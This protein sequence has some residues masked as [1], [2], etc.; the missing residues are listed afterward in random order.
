MKLKDLLDGI[1]ILDQ[2]CDLSVDIDAIA[3]DSRKVRQGSLF[4]CIE[5]Y[6]TDGHRYALQAQNQSV[7]AILLQKPVDGLTVPWVRVADT[8][9]ALAYVSDRFFNHPSGR[10]ELIGL[11][12]TK[13]KTTATYMTR[14]ILA[15][16]GR[17]VGLIGTNQNMIGERV[18]PT[19][20]TTPESYELQKLFRRMA[21]KGDIYL[22][23]YEGWYSVRDEAYYDE[24]ELVAGP[25]GCKLSPQGT[26]V[27]W[28]V[29]ES[30]FFRLSAY[31]DRLLAFYDANPDFIQPASRRNE[32]INF[33][34][35]G[36]SDLSISRTSFDWGVPVP[37]APGHVMY[38]WVDALTN[39]LTG[40]GFPGA[41][42]TARW[43]ADVHVIGKDVVRFHAIYWPAFLM[44]ADV[45]LPGCVFGH[46]FVLN[47]GEKM[48]K[49]LGNVVEPLALAELYGVD[50]LRYFLLR[51]VPFGQDGSYSHD[52]IVARINGDLAN[53]LGNLAQR[54][55]SMIAKN[56]D[57]ILPA[58]GPRT[59]EDEA[60]YARLDALPGEVDAAMQHF[61]LHQ[62]LEQV[63][64]VVSEA[65]GYIAAQAPWTVRKT[66]PER[67]ATILYNVA[68]AVRRFA[69]LIQPAMPVSGGKLLD[70]LAVPADC[71]DFAALSHPLKPGLQLPAPEGVFPRWVEADA[72]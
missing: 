57:G 58:P 62:A 70:L 60:F 42:Y 69:I 51:E 17:K 29:E 67:A 37:D 16:D 65:N 22:D 19:E 43:P 12:G 11:T 52:A 8:R 6:V 28:T 53:D 66:D 18:L 40:A 30:Y 27:E 34:K 38:V 56:L 36:L 50:Q 21:D 55:L 24:K 4:V 64:R 63:F 45:A 39:Y 20:R 10:L 15:A 71:R 3:Y 54:S 23:R 25:D 41:D 13:G 48:S 32:M 14:A 26:P 2:N 1:E 46:G 7:S 31:Q 47:K 49:S 35:G 33:V 72:V 5:G 68:E 9:R 59:A 44:S 61:A